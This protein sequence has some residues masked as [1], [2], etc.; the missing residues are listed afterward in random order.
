[1]DFCDCWAR[2]PVTFVILSTLFISF[3]GCHGFKRTRWH[4][5]SDQSSTERNHNLSISCSRWSNFWPYGTGQLSKSSLGICMSCA[6]WYERWVTARE[7]VEMESIC[8]TRSL[9]PCWHIST[10]R[11]CETKI[12]EEST[13]LDEIPFL[14]ALWDEDDCASL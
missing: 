8:L 14:R 9:R 2:V 10:K 5:K 7:L 11:G 4:T 6:Q 13:K 1:M 12:S 3:W